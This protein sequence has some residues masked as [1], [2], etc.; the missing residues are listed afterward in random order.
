MCIQCIGFI[1]VHIY[2]SSSDTGFAD[3]D[4][5]KIPKRH[6][7]VLFRTSSS[8]IGFVDDDVIKIA[9]RHHPVLPRMLTLIN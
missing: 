3:G 5:I 8:D 2:M 7:R 6:H 4:I 1:G 9:K